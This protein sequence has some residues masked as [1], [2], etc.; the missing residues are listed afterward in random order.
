MQIVLSKK[1]NLG[2]L[3]RTA[4]QLASIGLLVVAIGAA[5]ISFALFQALSAEVV[6][7]VI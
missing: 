6:V 4:R 7:R 5:Q 2:P 1:M 3:T